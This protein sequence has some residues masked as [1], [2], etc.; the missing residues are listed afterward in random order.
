MLLAGHNRSTLI[1]TLSTKNIKRFNQ[2]SNPSFD[3]KSPETNR[4]L[5]KKLMVNYI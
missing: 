1:A 2:A 3:A 4:L 5:K